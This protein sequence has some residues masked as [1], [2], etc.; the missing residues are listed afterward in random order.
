[1]VPPLVTGALVVRAARRLRR[2]PMMGY[3]SAHRVICIRWTLHT[4]EAIPA[5]PLPCVEELPRPTGECP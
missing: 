4:M 5:E 3:A 2:Q 1:M